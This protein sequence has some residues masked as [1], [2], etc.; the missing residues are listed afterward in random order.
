MLDDKNKSLFFSSGNLTLFSCKSLKKNFLLWELH[1][2]FMQ[3]PK[4]N[5][6]YYHFCHVFARNAVAICLEA[7]KDD[8]IVRRKTLSTGASEKGILQQG[9]VD[10]FL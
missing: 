3:I 6:L 5:P 2:I 8:R 1:S 10:E 7:G 4:K 9:I